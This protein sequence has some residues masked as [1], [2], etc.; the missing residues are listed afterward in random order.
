M[1][2]QNVPGKSITLASLH[3]MF[4]YVREE[5]DWDPEAL[6]LWGYFFTD[7]EP[8]KLEKAGDILVKKGYRYVDISLMEKEDESEQDLWCLNVEKVEAHTPESLDKRNDEFY[9]LADELG[10][11]SYDGMDVGPAEDDEK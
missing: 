1:A 5:T 8:K 9:A 10:L 4:D 2:E 11:V 6:M 3:E 7:H